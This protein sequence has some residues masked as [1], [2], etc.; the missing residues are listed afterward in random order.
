ME[1]ENGNVV[2]LHCTSTLFMPR[3]ALLEHAISPCSSALEPTIYGLNPPTD[4]EPSKTFFLQI[5]H[6]WYQVLETRK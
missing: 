5:V 2:Q 3:S 6:V 1:P 4:H